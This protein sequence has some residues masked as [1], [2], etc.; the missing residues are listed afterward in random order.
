MKLYVLEIF[1][2]CF[3]LLL[4]KREV[5]S[6]WTYLCI[7]SR[8]LARFCVG[9]FCVELPFVDQNS[10]I[11]KILGFVCVLFSILTCFLRDEMKMPFYL[12]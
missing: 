3:H 10:D 11:S 2:Y 5:W 9:C 8:S 12:I 7:K 1:G 6:C 4:I